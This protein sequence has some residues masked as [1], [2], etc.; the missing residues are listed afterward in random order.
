MLVAQQDVVV[1]RRRRLGLRDLEVLA[2]HLAPA[3]DRTRQVEHRGAQV[4]DGGVGVA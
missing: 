2:R 1:G 4:G 3:D